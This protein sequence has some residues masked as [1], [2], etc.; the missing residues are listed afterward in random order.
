MR[1][2]RVPL[3]QLWRNVRRATERARLPR[4]VRVD[5]YGVECRSLTMGSRKLFYLLNHLG[6]PVR[7]E[8]KSEWAMGGATDLRTMTK[9]DAGELN[10]RSLEVRLI[11]VK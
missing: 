6:K 5:K 11:E 9:L 3:M 1:R 4:L 7:I 8:C 2:P 10:M